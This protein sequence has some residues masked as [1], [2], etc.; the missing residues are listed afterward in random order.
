LKEPC[1]KFKKALKEFTGFLNKDFWGA[2]QVAINLADCLK[3]FGK[4]SEAIKYYNEAVNFLEKFQKKEKKEIAIDKIFYA[5]YNKAKLE[6]QEGSKISDINKLAE[7]GKKMLFELRDSWNIHD[8]LKTIIS[9][10]DLFFQIDESSE[11]AS[12]FYNKLIWFLGAYREHI[13]PKM[14]LEIARHAE[15]NPVYGRRLSLARRL[16]LVVITQIRKDPKKKKE[17]WPIVRYLAE[18][19]KE[20]PVFSYFSEEEIANIKQYLKRDVIEFHQDI[21]QEKIKSKIRNLMADLGYIESNPLE[22]TNPNSNIYFKISTNSIEITY[23][24]KKNITDMISEYVKRAIK[25]EILSATKRETLAKELQVKVENIINAIENLITVQD[26]IEMELNPQPIVEYLN[27]SYHEIKDVN[28]NI[29]NE[30]KQWID[31]LSQMDK[32]DPDVYTKLKL[33]LEKWRSELK[34]QSL[35]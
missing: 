29:A 28:A 13:P 6:L 12:E 22:F 27:K 35:I 7:Y 11:Y 16:M 33:D 26:M 3:D 5:L 10:L 9:L 21:P 2:G 34:K 23:M 24:G 1:G 15:N 19:F 25:A 18:V 17:Y 4:F 14:I 32:P 20:F 31:F 8:Y 30:I